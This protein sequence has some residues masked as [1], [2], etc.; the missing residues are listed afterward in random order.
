LIKYIKISLLIGILIF[1][2]SL[3]LDPFT[4]NE[5]FYQEYMK[6][7]VGESEKFYKLRES[8]LTPK[9]Y[10]QDIGITISLICVILLIF[11]KKG[12]GYIKSPK[13]KFFFIILALLLPFFTVGGFVFD[14]LQGMY[15]N[16]F[17]HWADS[18][19]IPMMGV[20]IQFIFLLLWSSLHL[21]F[22]KNLQISSTKFKLSTIKKINAWLLFISFI[23]GLLV[24]SS[25]LYGQY[26]YSIPGLLW[27]YYYL[28]IGIVKVTEQ[29]PNK[30]FDDE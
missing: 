5:V 27:I 23:S 13:N 14:I 3:F 18:L 7:S 26:W 9:Y 24:I 25:L 22:L 2:Y 8:M 17:P 4:N 20:P 15:R 11:L 12:E 21:L 6:L 1:L 29:S 16:E 19:A 30:A 10:L 28:S